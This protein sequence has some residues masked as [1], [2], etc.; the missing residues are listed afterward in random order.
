MKTASVAFLESTYV[1]RT[2]ISFKRTTQT[3]DNFQ[4]DECFSFEYDFMPWV[5]YIL[6]SYVLYI[7]WVIFYIIMIFM[8]I[9][10][11]QHIYHAPSHILTFWLLLPVLSVFCAPSNKNHGIL[12][13]PITV[14]TYI[15]IYIYITWSYQVMVCIGKMVNIEFIPDNFDKCLMFYEL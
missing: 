1:W 3:T 8:Y 10:P 4:W 15:Y 6:L 14:V 7:T 5:W 2:T 9:W 13:H 11:L 12:S